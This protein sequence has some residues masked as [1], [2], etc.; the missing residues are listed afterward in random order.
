MKMYQIF[1]DEKSKGV[2]GTLSEALKRAAEI[3]EKYKQGCLYID[4]HTYEN[5]NLVSEK[6]IFCEDI[7]HN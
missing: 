1:V 4:E 5:E 6:T 3:C 7:T 2:R